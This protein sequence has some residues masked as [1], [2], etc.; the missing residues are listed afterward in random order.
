M[1]VAED[2]SQPVARARVSSEVLG[3]PYVVV[4][5]LTLLTAG[6][7]SLRLDYRAVH[8]D[9][10]IS[11]S[12][13]HLSW[14][15]LWNV[16]VHED[17]NMSVYYAL[18]KIWTGV[19]GD[20]LLAV[21]SLS[22]LA[23][24]LCVP[25]VYAISVRLFDVSAGL[26][27]GL[28]LSTNVFF[29]RYAQ[30]ARAYALVALLAALSTYFFLAE[31]GRRRRWSRA[32]YVISTALAFY[33]HF[34]IV[35]VVLVH[36]LTLALHERKRALER[37]WLVTYSAIGLLVAP[38]AYTALGLDGDP[39][40]WLAEPGW[41]AVPATL[42]QLAGNSFVHVGALVGICFLALRRAARSRRLAFGLAFTATWA[43]LPLLVTFAVS[44]IKPILL[45]KYL[46][47]S[48]P[49]MA[50]LAAGAIT[51]L[52]PVGLA[53]GAACVLLALSAAELRTWYAFRGQEDWRSLAAF[54]AQR[55]RPGDGAVYNADYARASVVDYARGGMPASLP[56]DT[57][58]GS[59]A[60]RTRVWLVL[61]HSQ[62]VTNALRSAL[63]SH[64]CLQSRHDF[65]GDIA[66][67][68]Y[69]RRNARA[70]SG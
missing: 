28:L 50:L 34:F 33:V 5:V 39:I 8:F 55:E 37:S 66:V 42:A 17:P 65:D 2:A 26:V 62:Q 14:S 21:R 31:L 4:A 6:F 7:G 24:A 12:R 69:V 49:A 70:C 45:A 53:V 10:A 54:V 59:T 1:R 48:L 19:F 22:V 9:E 38:M 13:T 68:L 43:V 44:Q 47:V 35:W 25:V 40:G 63:S 51:S 36:G 27:A 32:G 52:R 61:A 3:H 29:L 18:L 20:S 60:N 58:L 15:G 30:E 11:M 56:A 67:E 16:V 23:A 57:R 41:G 46:I 64:Y